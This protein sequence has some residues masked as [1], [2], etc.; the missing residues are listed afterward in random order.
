MSSHRITR[1]VLALAAAGLMAAA[2]AG[3]AQAADPVKY[4][5]LGDSYSAGS[6]VLPLTSYNPV[7]LQSAR[8]WAHDIASA[9]GYQLTDVSCGAAQ[10]KDLR[11]SQYLGVAPQL[12][13]VS[14]DTDVVT[15]TMGGNDNNTFIG[16]ITACG[17]AAVATAGFGS[18]CKTLYG[19]T[20]TNAINN[21]TY[22][23]LVQGLRDIKAKAPNAKVMI[24]GYPWI[25]PATGSCYPQLPIARGDVAYL[26]DL[27]TVLNSAV[28]RAAA[29]TGATYVDLSKVSAGHDACQ[30]PDVRWVE[31]AIFTTQLVPVH[32]NA[33][34][35][36]GMADAAVKQGRL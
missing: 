23:A 28:S 31:P 17:T 3:P 4:V 24:S 2:A 27:Q 5:N 12:D 6:G 25:T 21:E 15:I 16:A 30:A 34:G 9:K 32:P 7:C 20:F 11:G 29:D 22:P 26:H 13:A 36:Q 8:N 35:E 10:T 18:P 14:A 33:L 19:D 1:S